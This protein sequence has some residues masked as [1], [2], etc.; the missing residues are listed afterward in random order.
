MQSLI[1]QPQHTYK[2]RIHYILSINP[3]SPE[4][5]LLN[6][7]DS[8]VARLH[9]PT[10]FY[11]DMAILKR[12]DPTLNE[13]VEVVFLTA[14]CD[15]GVCIEKVV[16]NK[17]TNTTSKNRVILTGVPSR[18]DGRFKVA[19]SFRETEDGIEA[20]I[21]SNFNFDFNNTRE[22][23]NASAIMRFI[24]KDSGNTFSFAEVVWEFDPES[25]I[26][27]YDANDY[28]DECG[29][30]CIVAVVY[31]EGDPMGTSFYRIK[32]GESGKW[33]MSQIPV[34][35]REID[36]FNWH[37]EDVRNE[38]MQE[39]WKGPEAVQLATLPSPLCFPELGVANLTTIGQWVSFSNYG[40]RLTLGVEIDNRMH[41]LSSIIS[42]Q[43]LSNLL[44]VT[45]NQIGHGEIATDSG[46][47]II[48]DSNG[49]IT[50]HAQVQLDAAVSGN[51]GVWVELLWRW[52]EIKIRYVDFIENLYSKL[53]ELNLLGTLESSANKSLVAAIAN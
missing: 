5:Y 17:L 6:Q 13:K 41:S 36:D 47:R 26:M 38:T 52:A 21:Q 40:Q 7:N 32:R 1:E 4:L 29:D 44:E 10:T 28:C 39:Q 35:Q 18:L 30:L 31:K 48:V 34:L 33:E 24:S 37:L 43:T 46:G 51:E 49:Y 25:K 45:I 22:G 9:A 23:A 50:L 53:A 2:E 15:E 27:I 8:I 19:G 12:L 3:E 42:A 20:Y 16:N 11:K 14:G